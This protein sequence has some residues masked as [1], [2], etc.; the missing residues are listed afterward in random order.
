MEPADKPWRR[1]FEETPGKAASCIEWSVERHRSEG[2]KADMG[3][4]AKSRSLRHGL[5]QC[6]ADTASRVV[7]MDRKLAEPVHPAQR[8]GEREA[9]RLIVGTGRN[10]GL[11]TVEDCAEPVRRGRRGGGKRRVAVPGKQHA[12]RHLDRDQPPGLVG[13]GGADQII[14]RQRASGQAS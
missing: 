9:D 14:R 6:A 13:P 7:G 3:E 12:R 1:L 10:H 11:A 5:D 2:G 8:L 4:A